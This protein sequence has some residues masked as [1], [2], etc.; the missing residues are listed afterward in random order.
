M[1]VFAVSDIHVDY[2]LNLKWVQGLSRSDHRDD[3]LILAGDVSHRPALLG[4]ALESLA[5]CFRRVLFVPGNHDLW[6]LG[7]PAGTTSLQKFAQVLRCVNDHGASM[8]PQRIGPVQFVPLLGWYDY[9]FGGPGDAL[10]EMWM[11]YRACS[12][13]PGWEPAEVARHFDGLNDEMNPA[14]RAREPGV[15]RVI[16]F[17]HFLPRIDLIPPYVPRR[18]REL[19]PVLGSVRLE[20]RLRGLRPDIHVYGHSHINRSVSL[21]GV[22]Y[23]NNALGYPQEDAIASRRLVCIAEA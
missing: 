16:S 2:A 17:S 13:P 9:S 18:H 22:R 12:W 20:D 21:G 3:V 1:R 15:T 7:E 6:V 8:A 19:D 14:P 4:N 11:D 5:T 23:V 10:R